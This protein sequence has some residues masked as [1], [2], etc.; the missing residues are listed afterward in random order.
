LNI[1]G[2]KNET[3]KTES[4]SVLTK[5]TLGMVLVLF[6]TLA[7][8][9]LITGEL[10]F[11]TP[12]GEIKGFLMGVFGYT[13][14]AFD[15]LLV[16]YGVKLVAD[17]KFPKMS[18]TA[19]CVLL[20]VI[21]GVVLGQAIT[22]ADLSTANFGE[23]MSACY[24]RGFG[25]STFGGVLFGL[26][27]F[28]LMAL[29]GSAGTYAVVA[30]LLALCVYGVVK[31]LTGNK[32]PIKREKTTLVTSSD[33]QETGVNSEFEEMAYP[34]DDAIERQGK[35]R[36][37]YRDD[38]F[39]LKTKKE[40]NDAER[41]AESF[42]IL[43][44]NANKGQ[45]GGLS[46]GAS[47]TTTTE[48]AKT[49][50][51]KYSSVYGE[52]MDKKLEYI[53]R[54]SEIKVE[55]ITDGWK[56]QTISEAIKTSG[57]ET[58]KEVPPMYVHDEE[59][60]TTE[61]DSVTRHADDYS[62]YSSIEETTM[63]GFIEDTD[64]TAETTTVEETVAENIDYGYD[65][66]QVETTDYGY[67]NEQ[68]ET[69]Q[70]AQDEVDDEPE[71]T[72][73]I[74]FTSRSRRSVIPTEENN[75]DTIEVKEESVQ[76]ETVLPSRR[77]DR[78]RVTET[79]QNE[80]KEEIKKEEVE[81]VIPINREY[82]RPPIEL[83]KEYKKDVNA[84]EENHQERSAIIERTL[85]EFGI[86]AKVVNYVQGPTVTRYEIM[87]PAGI[88]VRRVPTHAEDIAMRLEAENGVRIEAP[89]PGK[90]LVG[91]E[92]ANKIKTIVGLRDIIQSP[93]FNKNDPSKLMFAI[94]KDIVGNCISDNLAKGPHFLVAGAT[95]MG[96][97]VCLN[98]MIIS[99][100]TKYSPEELR[101]ILIDPKQ[102]EFTI[103]DHLPHLMI[104]EIIN[105]PQKA[106]AILQW[107]CNEMENRY[108]IFKENE[109]RDIDE[110][111]ETIASD[112]V[113]K[114]PKLVIIVDEVSDLMQYAKRELEARI[115]SL[116]QKARA[117]GIH[118]VLATQRPS[119]DVITGVIKT[120]L[121]S[122][123]A[124]RV[125][126]AVDSG[127]I[128]SE[129]GAEKL[130]GN[131]DMLYRNSVMPKCIRYQGA[132]I[133]MSEVKAIV[134]YIKENNV[135]YFDQKAT[136]EIEKTLNPPAPETET[137][138]GGGSEEGGGEDKLF[139]DALRLVITAGSASISML[140]R[141][142]SVGYAKA[143]G[144]IDKMDR[145][146]YISPFDGSRARQVL[147]T[148]EQFEEKYGEF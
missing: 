103:Y 131:G 113:A 50:D 45:T 127:T 98:S 62:R 126:S 108:T 144:L 43:Y 74:G 64:T 35:V 36:L 145:M 26:I 97:S 82:F 23:Y 60:T 101:L 93:E 130:L 87:M 86:D 148:K 132:F 138:E 81:Q 79:V 76:E 88:P 141:R 55:K 39:E 53:R 139:I 34:V 105:K 111:N 1:F 142:F 21:L 83:F 3:E 129:G 7:L 85:S 28:P 14:Y 67:S 16:V 15:L 112:T 143:G 109:V 94:G 54:P 115:L 123:I 137:T 29:I 32:K 106:I 140:Q 2:R 77:T 31:S 11:S 25:S 56:T 17:K 78:L 92:V 147:I 134:K 104:D 12:G 116:S 135:A 9:C 107:A 136:E 146:G 19:I 84:G 65:N 48:T 51:Q 49:T 80:V 95:G 8:V 89:I 124:F 30:V 13:A 18:K 72:N 59:I 100:I 68:I 75:D 90:N 73:V 22:T 24:G 118:L 120:N 61:K 38:N 69:T 71:T 10:V 121:P 117:A 63:D 40:I 125:G 37:V 57:E 47:D 6:A 70:T 58:T 27:T 5:E 128:L 122:R 20:A 91:I 119:V 4:V 33:E 52:D 44:P 41:R 114:I 110:Y 99:L 46:Y 96:K 66:E 133:S 42:K 102:V